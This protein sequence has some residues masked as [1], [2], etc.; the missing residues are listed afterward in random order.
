MN[1]REE[2]NKPNA[3]WLYEPPNEIAFSRRRRGAR[4]ASPPETG[5]KT[6]VEQARHSGGALLGDF[7]QAGRLRRPGE[8]GCSGHGEAI[9]LSR[10]HALRCLRSR[11]RG[12][13][14][15]RE[16]EDTPV[17]ETRRASLVARVAWGG[18]WS[19]PSCRELRA[20]GGARAPLA[21]EGSRLATHARHSMG[22]N[23]RSRTKEV[24]R[25][26][27]QSL[28]GREGGS[29]L[30]GADALLEA[31]ESWSCRS[32]SRCAGWRSPNARMR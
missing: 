29:L 31:S 30:G 27:G 10:G 5:V 4:E 11:T 24:C 28:R 15:V 32:V 25:Q 26:S 17:P 2:A 13:F 23:R 1:Q 7:T 22:D 14:G 20:H 9:Q 3:D 6:L 19:P 8:G 16:T 12:N 21:A 18:A